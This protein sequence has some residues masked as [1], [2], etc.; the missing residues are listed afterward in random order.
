MDMG[1]KKKVC[2]GRVE[3]ADYLQSL[4][5]QLRRGQLETEGR[6]W[7]VPEE[8]WSEIRLK[9]KQGYIKAKMSFSWSTEPQYDQAALA[10]LKKYRDS[11][12]EVKKRL[13]ASYKA[14]SQ[15]A[16]QGKFPDP[17]TLTEFMESSQAMGKLADPEWQEA[18]K[19]YL[20]HLASLQ[21][22]VEKQDFEAML[23]ELRDLEN[24]K[25]DCHREFK[26][27]G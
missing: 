8:V 21:N 13:T 7:T 5:E 2:L 4:S 15:M 3:L 26:S 23:H 20:D 11:M 9:E 17:K 12:T 1:K 27:K 16:K 19:I 25:V 24:C 22:A 18:M 10:D 6:Q 14:I